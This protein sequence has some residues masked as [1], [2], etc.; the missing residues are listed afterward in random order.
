MGRK[1]EDAAHKLQIAE[2][3]NLALRKNNEQYA[4][5][6]K[7]LETIAGSYEKEMDARRDIEVSLNT[8]TTGLQVDSLADKIKMMRISRRQAQEDLK[9][10]NAPM[11]V[12]P[13]A[14]GPGN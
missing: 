3:M 9:R 13:P 11:E 14:A 10:M 6:M 2:A 8:D 4:L 12:D 1:M 5:R 7:Y